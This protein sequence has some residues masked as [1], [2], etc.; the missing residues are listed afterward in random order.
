[1]TGK[2]LTISHDGGTD[3]LILYT[4][5]KCIGGESVAPDLSV[6]YNRDE[7]VIEVVVYHAAKMLGP[8]LFPGDERIGQ[9]NGFSEAREMA[10]AYAP[11][12]DTLRLQTGDP[13]YAGYT[14]KAV[15]AGLF[16]N[17]DPEGWAMGVRLERAAA[18]LRPY[19]RPAA[20]PVVEM[21]NDAAAAAV[22]PG[23]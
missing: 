14:E 11:G 3:T 9:A 4:D 15:A 12:S 5:L 17:F 7:E 20:G 8:H 19:L 1:M 13:P 10:V 2:S 23:V 6:H 21:T 18:R 22:R 16:V